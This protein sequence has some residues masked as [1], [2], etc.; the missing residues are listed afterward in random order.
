[1][2][3][4]LATLRPPKAL[5]LRLFLLLA[6]ATVAIAMAADAWRL[7]QERTR[8]LGQ[9]QREASLVTKAIEGQV[10]PL[11]AVADDRPLAALLED[12]RQAK[13]AEC[14]AVYSL[15]G[16]RL[17][18]AFEPGVADRGPD[19]CA[20]AITP[21]PTAEAV[22]AQWSGSGTYNIQIPLTPADKPVAILK[23][24]FDA[25]RVSGPLQEFRNSVVVERVLVLLAMGAT[26]WLGG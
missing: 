23:M 15:A 19:I 9:L 26:L 7:R 21:T 18:A 14:V 2:S 3:S 6:M 10:R 4:Y 22:S 24:V 20:S 5:G 13:D 11:L 12:I 17:R 8:V 1:V 16:R 25:A